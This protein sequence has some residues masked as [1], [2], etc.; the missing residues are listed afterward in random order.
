MSAFAPTPEQVDFVAAVA[1]GG[2][3][4]GIAFAGA[5]KTSSLRL[6]AEGPLRRKKIVNIC[7]NRA[8]RIEADASM[9][10]HVKNKT[11][12]Q[13]AWP[14]AMR[15]RFNDRKAWGAMGQVLSYEGHPGLEP[16]AAF[17]EGDARKAAIAAVDALT[18]FSHS[19]D[20]RILP[21]HIARAAGGKMED[22]AARKAARAAAAHGLQA[23][24][25][26][27]M[28]PESDLLLTFDHFLKA[29]ALTEPVLPYDVVL[30]DEA[31]DTNPVTLEIFLRQ[32]RL[33][34]Q[35][36][37]V[38]DSHQAIYGFR[39]ATDGMKGGPG[40]RCYLTRSFRFGPEVAAWANVVL[41]I[42][43][44]PKPLIGAGPAGEVLEDD[45]D[46]EA[47]AILCRGN[48]G[49]LREAVAALDAGKRV[50]V[51]GGTEDAVKLLR[52][53][54]AL[55]TEG[56]TDHP[57]LGLFASWADFTE[58]TETDEG[59]HLRPI[60][61]TIDEYG[62]QVPTL[63]RRLETE[64]VDEKDSPDVRISTA[65]KGKGLE[66]GKVKLAGDFPRLVEPPEGPEGEA[67][68][69]RE[70]ANLLY[71]A[72][73]RAKRVL[74]LGDIGE[75][76]RDDAALLS[77]RGGPSI[78]VPK[79]P[80]P[81][82]EPAEEAAQEAAPAPEASAPQAPAPEPEEAQQAPQTPRQRKYAE[83]AE[84]LQAAR[85][86]FMEL[87]RMNMADEARDLRDRA[88]ANSDRTDEER[89]TA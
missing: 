49:V 12:H 79:R 45:G 48:A 37:M 40:K 61:K 82:P 59:G 39:G 56:K 38:G 33:G 16:L 80:A 36:I 69:N 47:D 10:A 71:V 50:A 53:A 41:G 89:R 86:L 60:V 81:A 77:D 23:L 78:R 1:T 46:G 43:G 85:R 8:N 11:W 64:T 73:T 76:L 14:T 15:L 26:D 74:N 57:E 27:L 66:F 18:K 2:P 52:A 29:W 28:R 7:F 31:Q 3:V 55:R 5:G 63:C 4:Q 51:V 62:E 72:I 75:R 20:K 22:A 9:P 35:A 65:H 34:K 83:A 84:H 6:A 87:G 88:A 25:D 30:L 13:L 68:V 58:H 21:K 54:H 32:H 44:E 19:A 70:E 42:L 24:W 17:F 67:T